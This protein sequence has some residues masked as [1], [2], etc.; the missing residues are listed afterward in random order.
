MSEY[1]KFALGPGLKQGQAMVLM[2][3]TVC[4]CV[5]LYE[6]AEYCPYAELQN[7][8]ILK[9]MEFIFYLR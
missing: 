8:N 6:R 2:C 1:L 5:S 4:V 9:N 3:V 7:L